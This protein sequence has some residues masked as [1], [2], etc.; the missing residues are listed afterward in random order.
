MNPLALSPP[1]AAEPLREWL[2]ERGPGY[3]LR[4]VVPRL[5]E[6][7]VASWSDATDLPR[8]LRFALDQA[9]PLPRLRLITSQ[10]S[11]DGTRKFLWG[12]ADGA[13]VESVLI[14]EG[15]RRTLC[16]SSQSGCAYGCV[17]CATGR[18]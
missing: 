12:L 1:E 4:Q 2:T 13:A 9:F 17:F 11:N 15:R 8:D 7:P 6:R 3:R 14:P 16:I 5:W 18:M 10:L